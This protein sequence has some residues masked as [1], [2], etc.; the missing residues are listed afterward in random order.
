MTPVRSIDK[1]KVWQEVNDNGV[2]KYAPFRGAQEDPS[3]KYFKG[4]M[5]E[6]KNSGHTI[7]LETKF[8]DFISALKSSKPSVSPNDIGKYIDFTKTFGM[9]G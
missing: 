9:D 4:N 3:K 7:Y 8:D 5:Q 6:L 1:V 2:V